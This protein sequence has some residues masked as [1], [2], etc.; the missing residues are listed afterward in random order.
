MCGLIG[1]PVGD[2]SISISASAAGSG[3]TPANAAIPAAPAVLKKLR[4]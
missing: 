1:G 3:R 4:R 2:G